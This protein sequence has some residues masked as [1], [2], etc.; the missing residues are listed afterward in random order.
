MILYF[1]LIFIVDY[2]ER[3]GSDIYVRSNV[4]SWSYYTIHHEL[5]ILEK[6]S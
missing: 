3:N 6:A 2:V 4:Q 1:N 5:T